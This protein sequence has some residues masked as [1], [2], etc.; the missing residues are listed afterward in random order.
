MKKKIWITWENHRR[1]RELAE[2]LSGVSLFVL[3]HNGRRPIRYIVLSIK[4]VLLLFR[5]KPTLV[6]VQNPSIILT[7]VV[8]LTK[9]IL[10]Y[11]VLVDAHNEG[12]RPFYEHH[13]WLLPIY[14]FLQAKASLTIV[15]NEQLA[16]VVQTNGGVP[17]IL[18]D[19][20]PDLVPTDHLTLKGKHNVV[21]I[22][23]YEK[24]E[25][26]ENVIRAGKLLND[27]T[28]LYVT[29]RI[30]KAPAYIL[31]QAPKNVIFCGFL[32]EQDYINLL[33]SCDVVMDL[34]L[35]E[36]C[37]VCG[38]YEALALEKPMILSDTRALRSYFS[39]GV[40]YTHSAAE[41]IACSISEAIAHNDELSNKIK[42]LKQKIIND[43]DVKRE[44]LESTIRNL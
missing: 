41:A 3:E 38:A 40:V 32:A 21:Y 42:H 27:S 36:D 28:F 1:T 23:T 24:D 14:A 6:F 2:H 12:L 29:G 13:N 10:R 16:H 37:L 43:W 35:M 9:Y 17:F 31:E 44:C 33:D 39:Q 4:T 15:T 18:E 22:C 20:I 30:E 25:P 5:H 26:Y 11:H 8:V 34:T 7:Y 19:R